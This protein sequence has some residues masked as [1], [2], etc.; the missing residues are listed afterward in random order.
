M[1]AAAAGT[2]APSTTRA[3]TD[4]PRAARAGPPR[5][6]P[7]AAALRPPPGPIRPAPGR[8]PGT[9]PPGRARTDVPHLCLLHPARPALRLRHP[10]PVHAARPGPSCGPLRRISGADRAGTP[11]GSKVRR[12]VRVRARPRAGGGGGRGDDGAEGQGRPRRWCRVAAAG[13]QSQ[14]RC[15]TSPDARLGMQQSQTRCHTSPDARLGMQQSQTR[16]VH[17]TRDSFREARQCHTSPDSEFMMRL[18][19]ATRTADGT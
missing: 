2:R 13:G 10:V 1:R 18:P 7:P 17:A 19:G 8:G 9:G 16:S 4:P 12:A 14:T 5:R 11:D 6:T 3:S 15:H